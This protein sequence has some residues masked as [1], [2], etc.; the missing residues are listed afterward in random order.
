MGFTK[1]ESATFFKVT[2]YLLTCRKIVN[3]QL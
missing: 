1:A 3:V 2:T